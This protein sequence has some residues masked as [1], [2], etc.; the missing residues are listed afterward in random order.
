MKAKLRK[1][2]H[3]EGLRC[4]H[5]RRCIVEALEQG[6]KTHA[7]LLRETQLDRVTV[8]RNLIA[9]QKIGIVYRVYL[10]G[11]EPIYVLCDADSPTHA[12][13]FCKNCRKGVCLPPGVIQLAEPWASYTE[14]VLL[15]GRCPEC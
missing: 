4:T 15:L 2:L 6:P 12:H 9:L 14:R 7:Q 1:R 13:F 5:P 3:A 10:P 8:Y 11:H